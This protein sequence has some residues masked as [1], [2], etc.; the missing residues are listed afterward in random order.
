MA[1]AVVLADL[2]EKG[3]TV[4]VPFQNTASYDLVADIEG[5]LIKIQCKNMNTA[6]DRAT[7]SV[8]ADLRR[9][10][11]RRD[12]QVRSDA[13]DDNEVDLFA[14]YISSL[15]QVVYT[16]IDEVG[17]RSFTI[18]LRDPSDMAPGNRKRANL[19]RDYTFEKAIARFIGR[20]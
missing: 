1:E 15:E 11:Y 10:S 5:D 12:G 8:K 19:P 9:R 6:Q 17:D 4:S 2:V 7:N 3:V 20:D 14:F 16:P 13:Y 18:C